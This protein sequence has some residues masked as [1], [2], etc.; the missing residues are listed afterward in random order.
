[1]PP[2]SSGKDPHWFR[3]YAPPHARATRLHTQT[4]VP[5][6]HAVEWQANQHD[7]EL[8]RPADVA[9]YV[10]SSVAGAQAFAE[11]LRAHLA[12]Q[13]SEVLH[14]VVLFGYVCNM[15]VTVHPSMAGRAWVFV[16]SR[17]AWFAC[18]VLNV[19]G[20]PVTTQPC[21][22]PLQVCAHAHALRDA[23]PYEMPCTFVIT[24][25]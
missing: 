13:G 4:T 8:V 22:L 11:S 16:D 18:F 12:V 19:R 20:M 15:Y 3:L 1:M 21:D 9:V 24:V 6:V 17:A 2:S 5:A 10:S 25:M 23:T 7:S 14:A